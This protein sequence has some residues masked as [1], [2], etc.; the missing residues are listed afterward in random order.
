MMRVCWKC[1][2]RSGSPRLVNTIWP[3]LEVEFRTWGGIDI[4]LEVCLG[5]FNDAVY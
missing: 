3:Q 5:L 1:G 4:K 2:Q